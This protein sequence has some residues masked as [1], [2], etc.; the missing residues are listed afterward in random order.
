M[1]LSIVIE[2]SF[3]LRLVGLAFSHCLRLTFFGSDVVCD[4]AAG[5][6]L[7]DLDTSSLAGAE[8][9]GDTARGE[10]AGNES[11]GSS[12]FAMS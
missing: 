7:A 10:F 9:G 1:K 8:G 12:N 11:S 2:A 3:F 6:S 5:G 4:W